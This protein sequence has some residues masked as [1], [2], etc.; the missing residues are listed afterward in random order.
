VPA[1]WYTSSRVQFACHMGGKAMKQFLFRLALMS[2]LLA[3]CG[4]IP[5]RDVESTVQTVV[6]A[7]LTAQPT[8]TL[9]PKPT[10]TPTQTPGGEFE[11]GSNEREPNADGDEFPQH[12]VTLE[13]FWIDQTEVTNAQYQLCVEAGG[14]DPLVEPE[15]H[16]RGSYYGDSTYDD[17]PVI[18][19]RWHDAAAYCEWVGARL[20]TEAEWEYAARGRSGSAYPWGDN[21]PDET[22]LNYDQNVGDTTQ[23]GSYPDGVSWCG[24]L[25]MA[26][27]VWEWV[28][29]WY[30][31]YPPAAQTAPTG[32]ATGHSKV[33]RGGSW[34]TYQREVRTTNRIQFT[35]G[36]RYYTVGFR[37][38]LAR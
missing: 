38:A 5:A 29:D 10:S 35:A 17:H 2:F 37:C 6:A 30:D 20:P 33:L 7:T 11:M 19:V 1:L 22:L 21:P 32:P 27:N 28:G 16:I 9:T 13:S 31:G 18:Y 26:G 15:S 12:T 23:V 34:A 4:D 14:C 25:D 36:S 8:E 3:A 24:A